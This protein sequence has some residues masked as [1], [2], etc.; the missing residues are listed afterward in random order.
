M[1][2][3]Y[4][5]VS[6]IG[7]LNH[8]ISLILKEGIRGNILMIGYTKRD[9]ATPKSVERVARN[10]GELF[11][12][13]I[14]YELPERPND[15]NRKRIKILY[16]VYNNVFDLS[17]GDSLYFSCFNFHYN[18]LIQIAK[19]K[20]ATTHLVEEGLATYK[21]IIKREPRKFRLLPLVKNEIKNLGLRNNMVFNF[22][23]LSF[24]LVIDLFCLP[25]ELC[26]LLN[27]IY[28][29]PDVQKRLKYRFSREEKWFLS[30]PSHFDSVNVVFPDLLKNEF[31][32]ESYMK[33]EPF[34]DLIES[35]EFDVS[36]IRKGDVLI[37][38][39]PFPMKNIDMAKLIVR[40]IEKLDV[41]LS[42]VVIKLHPKDSF[43]YYVDL[44]DVLNK[45]GMSDV[46][47]IFS[48]NTPAEY[49]ISK[50]GIS[51]VI[52]ISSSAMVYAQRINN[53]V[54]AVSIRN[55]IMSELLKNPDKYRDAIT[56]IEDFS[57]ELSFFDHL[58]YL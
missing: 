28:N 4:F 9:L 36:H 50:C 41:P 5:V 48:D 22:A 46:R 7:M 31:F 15:F 51:K 32:A 21:T 16:E 58:E 56:V 39:Q 55:F 2:N 19:E 30:V 53:N 3:N 29:D 49:I 14:L 45:L 23:F 13:I 35:Q 57:K 33:I 42:K 47:V 25:F 43:D 54:K 37:L 6:N 8:Q 17:E 26:R 10:Y 20:G 27:E 40:V 52:S 38:N 12:D 44:L 34:K 18:L 24:K 11:I 1:A